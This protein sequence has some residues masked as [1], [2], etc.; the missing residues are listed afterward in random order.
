MNKGNNVAICRRAEVTKG[1]KKSRQSS[2]LD[3]HKQEIIELLQQGM[4][5]VDIAKHFGV[6]KQTLFHFLQT[7]QISHSLECRLKSAESKIIEMFKS[8]LTIKEMAKCLKTSQTAISQQIKRIKLSRSRADTY[9]KQTI[10]EKHGAQIK[11]MFDAGLTQ[12]AIAKALGVH[13]Q[14]IK[15]CV[16]QLG[17]TRDKISKPINMIAGREDI[18]LRMHQIG[19]DTKIIALV[20]NCTA[21]VVR[22][23]LRRLRIAPESAK[24]GANE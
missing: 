6:S 15:N 16:R 21:Q 19:I 18:L 7:N 5:K 8:G 14:S 1:Y 17:L 22:W 11:Q 20:F 13:V 4:T 24:R 23:H 3:K 12:Q 10:L 9:N 2:C